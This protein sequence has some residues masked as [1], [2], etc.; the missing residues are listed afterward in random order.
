MSKAI[1]KL[2]FSDLTLD[3]VIDY[4]SARYLKNI[5]KDSEHNE[6]LLQ[7]MLQAYIKDLL[8]KDWDALLLQYREEKK[9]ADLFEAFQTVSD[10]EDRFF[11]QSDAT[12]NFIHYCQLK[13]WRKEEAV[14]LFFGKNPEIVNLETLNNYLNDP[15]LNRRGSSSSF[16]DGY[17]KILNIINSDLTLPEKASPKDFLTWFNNNRML[18]PNYLRIVAIDFGI[19]RP[20]QFDWVNQMFEDIDETRPENTIKIQG[21]SFERFMP[22][23]PNKRAPDDIAELLQLVITD[24]INENNCYPKRSKIW[25]TLADLQNNKQYQ[26]YEVNGNIKSLTINGTNFSKRSFEKR[27]GNYKK[28]PKIII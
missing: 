9:Y 1:N 17:K 15:T 8:T 11:N 16:I 6:E 27:W 26:G 25:N 12:A 23:F 13:S 5:A 21:T 3:K 18:I 10:D 28:Q 22:N 4:L 2:D 24:Y 20:E 19:Q 14:A 7:K